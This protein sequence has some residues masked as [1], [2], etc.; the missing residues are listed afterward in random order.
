MQRSCSISWMCG[1]I[2]RT[3]DEE[4]MK[5]NYD[6]LMLRNEKTN[7]VHSISKVAVIFKLYKHKKGS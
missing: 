6:P 1:E 2:K 3:E 7:N 4:T 5:F